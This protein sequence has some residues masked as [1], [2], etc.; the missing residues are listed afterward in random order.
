M[1]AGDN[2]EYAW[3]NIVEVPFFHCY[4]AAFKDRFYAFLKPIAA[5]IEKL[6]RPGSHPRTIGPARFKNICKLIMPHTLYVDHAAIVV[7]TGRIEEVVRTAIHEWFFPVDYFFPILPETKFISVVVTRPSENLSICFTEGLDGWT[8]TTAKRLIAFR[9][10]LAL[11]FRKTSAPIPAVFL[12]D[13][14]CASITGKYASEK[15]IHIRKHKI[16]VPSLIPI[17][18]ENYKK[19][20]ITLGVEARGEHVQHYAFDIARIISNS[21]S[22]YPWTSNPTSTEELIDTLRRDAILPLLSREIIDTSCGQTNADRH[23]TRQIV[24][25]EL[26]YGWFLEFIERRGL[27]AKRG[28]FSDMIIEELRSDTIKEKPLG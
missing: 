23:D 1:S 3:K 21:A 25:R 7:G 19:S 8:E 5:Q 6:N 22:K 11:L 15:I 10:F 27:N 18:D 12:S 14:H 16:P 28:I 9:T 4:N 2:P 13:A 24:S 17:S 20:S 26:A